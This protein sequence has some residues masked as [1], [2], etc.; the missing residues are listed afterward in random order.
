MAYAT[1]AEVKD[2]DLSRLVTQAGWLDADVNDRIAEG[3]AVIDSALAQM[4]FN[5]LITL[6]ATVPALIKRLS[7][8]YARYACLR[9]MHHHFAP[10]QAGG[11][12]YKAYKDQFDALLAEVIEGKKAIVDASGNRIEPTTVSPSMRVQTN[13]ENLE[14]ALTM[15]DP[16]SEILDGVDYSDPTRLGSPE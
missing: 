9:D 2:K 14:R 11:E 4:G 8:L 13:T 6:F 7:I 12:S 1:A 10:S 3:D 16:E 15:G 5:D